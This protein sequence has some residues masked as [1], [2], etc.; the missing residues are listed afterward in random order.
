MS[1]RN[2]G[3]WRK[4]DEPLGARVRKCLR[5]EER[6]REKEIRPELIGGEGVRATT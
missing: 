2:V 3:G 6:G 5:R 1:D 4:R